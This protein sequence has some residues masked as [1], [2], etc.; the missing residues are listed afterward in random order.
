[1]TERNIP[2]IYDCGNKKWILKLWLKL[3]N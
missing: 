3:I 2:R 1:M